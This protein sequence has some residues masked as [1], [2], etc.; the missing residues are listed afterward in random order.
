M[1][2]YR[3]NYALVHG[4]RFIHYET[5][6]LAPDVMSAYNNFR[7][8]HEKMLRILNE[9]GYATPDYKIIK[10]EEVEVDECVHVPF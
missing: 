5:E 2:N 6:T 8:A 7:A 10:I 1:K 4:R 3:I 9:G